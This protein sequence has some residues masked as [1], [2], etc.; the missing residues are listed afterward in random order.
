MGART[1]VTGDG[2]ATSKFAKAL[3]I[4]VGEKVGPVVGGLLNLAAKLSTLGAKGIGWLANNL[5][6][7]AVVIAYALCNKYKQRK[8]K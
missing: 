2:K 1:V 3:A 7:L 6:F 5:W 8:E 4:K